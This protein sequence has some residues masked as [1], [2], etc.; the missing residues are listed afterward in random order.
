MDFKDAPIS[1]AERRADEQQDHTLWSPRDLLIKLLREIDNG[2]VNMSAITI[3]YISYLDPEKK[4][5]SS[6]IRRAGQEKLMETIAML[7]LAKY[8]LMK[9]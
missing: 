4:L 1:L 7:E 6:S 9:V 3:V 2:E 8:D 5:F